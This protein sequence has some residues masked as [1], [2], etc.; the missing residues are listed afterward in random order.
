MIFITA[1]FLVRPEYADEWPR[2]T[3][4]FTAATRAEPGCRWFDWSRS[5]DNPD[6]YVLVEAFADG[7]AGAAHVGSAHFRQAQQD[8]P[9][10]LAA[11]PRIISQDV[12]QDD[13]SELGEMAVK[14]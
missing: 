2:I 12:A 4:A 9:G 13:W 14:P 7:D 11:T 10:Y 5:L 1:K 8:L 3:S 6:E